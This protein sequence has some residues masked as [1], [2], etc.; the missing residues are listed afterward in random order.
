[1][2]RRTETSETSFKIL[3][4]LVPFSLWRL[5]PLQWSTG[6]EVAHRQIDAVSFQLLQEIRPNAGGAETA[7]N[8]ACIIGLFLDEAIDVLCLDVFALHANDLTDAYDFA[9]SVRQALQ[10]HDDRYGGC[11]LAADAANG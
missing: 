8:V 3:S 10:L 7:V 4:P 11:D 6:I 1:M 2:K 9:L 5:P